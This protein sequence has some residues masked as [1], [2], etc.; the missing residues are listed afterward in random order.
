M[1]ISLLVRGLG[2]REEDGLTTSGTGGEKIK[3]ITGYALLAIV[4]VLFAEKIATEAASPSFVDG[5]WGLSFVKI[6]T[7]EDISPLP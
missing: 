5:R 6:E 3:E 2:G 4:E 7:R 1:T